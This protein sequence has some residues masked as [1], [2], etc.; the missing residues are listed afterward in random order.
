[1]LKRAIFLLVSVCN[2]ISLYAGN[3]E[4]KKNKKVNRFIY[5]YQKNFLNDLK[6]TELDK[7]PLNGYASAFL[8]NKTF[9][10]N[11]YN[12]K[13]C[14]PAILYC[15]NNG[16]RDLLQT[17]WFK[18]SNSAKRLTILAC[19]YHGISPAKID[20]MDAVPCFFPDL[21]AYV[22]KFN[23]TEAKERRDEINFIN[24]HHKEISKIITNK[25]KNS[26][27]YTTKE[28]DK[29]INDGALGERIAKK[30]ERIN[31]NVTEITNISIP[32]Q[33]FTFCTSN[34]A[35][36]LVYK[37][38]LIL[39]CERWGGGRADNFIIK[40]IAGKEMLFYTFTSG[41]GVTYLY[42]GKYILGEEKPT[43]PKLS[44]LPQELNSWIKP[45]LNNPR[46][47]YKFIM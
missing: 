23:K 35:S 31:L 17:L 6:N 36:V 27:F 13:I 39:L 25:F 38:K 28:I 42:L 29:A 19:F 14:M 47:F 41:S 9:G 32:Y 33:V 40:K 1:M 34:G 43:F 18:S 8:G 44:K 20:S 46:V 45:F 7:V 30:A 10:L 5:D 37:G 26:N 11:F 21:H 2:F 24:K 3:V 12:P 4:V 15:Y 22:S 16:A